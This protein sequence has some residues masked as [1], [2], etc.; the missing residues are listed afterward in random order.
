MV[1][2]KKRVNT[3][4]KNVLTGLPDWLPPWIPDEPCKKIGKS[5]VFFKWLIK[6]EACLKGRHDP[7]MKSWPVGVL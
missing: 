7:G 5:L 4:G 2:K 1:L 3:V 6:V